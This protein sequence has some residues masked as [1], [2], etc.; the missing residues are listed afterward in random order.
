MILLNIYLFNILK[1]NKYQAKIRQDYIRRQSEN[2]LFQQAKLR[3]YDDIL[4]QI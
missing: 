1:M 2:E 3:R 4:F